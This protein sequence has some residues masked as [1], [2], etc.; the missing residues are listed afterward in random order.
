VLFKTIRWD[1]SDWKIIIIINK[2]TTIAAQTARALSKFK[3]Q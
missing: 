1:F 3:Q 2:L